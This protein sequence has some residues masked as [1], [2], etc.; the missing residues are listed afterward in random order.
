MAL[1]ITGPKI[2]LFS[3]SLVI[4]VEALGNSIIS[5]TL[6]EISFIVPIIVKQ[7]L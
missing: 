3:F 1:K 4:V 7:L 6:V 2:Y 5:V